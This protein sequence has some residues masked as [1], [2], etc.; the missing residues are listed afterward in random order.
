MGEK[1]KIGNIAA[2]KRY[3]ECACPIAP[4]GGQKVPVSELKD[5]SADAK[6]ELGPL[7]FAELERLGIS[8]DAE[9]KK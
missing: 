1:K 7:A 2:I 8:T 6:A 4:N 9:E 5:L 3:F